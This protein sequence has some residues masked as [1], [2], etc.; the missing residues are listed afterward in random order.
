MKIIWAWLIV[1]EKRIL[2]IKRSK[3][4][5]I[6]N[7]PNYWSFPWWRHENNETPEETAIREV[8]EEIWVDFFITRTLDEYKTEYTSFHHFLWDYSWTIILQEEECDWYGWFT[9]EETK[10][11]LINERI[12]WI[13]EKLH[14]E[15]L[16]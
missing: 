4:K 1:K 3:N 8:K 5:D 10:K 7:F 11:M 15:E 13:L 2:M 14:R 6:N 9:Y 12:N 16:I